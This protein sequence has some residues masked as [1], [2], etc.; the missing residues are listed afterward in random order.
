MDGITRDE[1]HIEMADSRL[2]S[3]AIKVEIKLDVDNDKPHNKAGYSYIDNE[4]FDNELQ[5]KYHG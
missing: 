5:R 1:M 3:G 4:I 2:E